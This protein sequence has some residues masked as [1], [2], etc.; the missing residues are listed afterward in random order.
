MAEYYDEHDEVLVDAGAR[1]PSRFLYDRR[2]RTVTQILHDPDD[3]NEW[4]LTA[5]V[6]LDASRDAGRAVLE[7]L[8]I[9]RA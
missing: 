3:T 6:D 9:D 4:R 8:D 2:A 5:R 1:S 7:L